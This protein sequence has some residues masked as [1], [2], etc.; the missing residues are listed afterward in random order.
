MIVAGSQ[1]KKIHLFCQIRFN[2]TFND[3]SQPAGN[4][5]H[6]FHMTLS[7]IALLL[8]QRV[9]DICGQIDGS[10]NMHGTLVHGSGIGSFPS[11]MIVY[12]PKQANVAE[13]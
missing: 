6:D 3:L 5:L 13:S 11:L 4:Y 2:I 1:S 8:V 9:C 10:Y 7:Y 12:V